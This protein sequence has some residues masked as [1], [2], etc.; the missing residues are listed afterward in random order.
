MT[1]PNPQPLNMTAILRDYAATTKASADAVAADRRHI[2]FIA[3]R[4]VASILDPTRGMD[5]DALPQEAK[6]ILLE[7]DEALFNTGHLAPYILPNGQGLGLPWEAQAVVDELRSVLA[8]TDRIIAKH[9]NLP[10]YGE[11]A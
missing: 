1:N 2:P 5:L 7:L 4:L 9:G 10:L 11:D 3:A 6:D 8:E